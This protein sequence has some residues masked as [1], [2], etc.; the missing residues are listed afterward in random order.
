MV[1]IKFDPRGVMAESSP[2][3]GLVRNAPNS[4]PMVESPGTIEDFLGPEL[5]CVVITWCRDSGTQDLASMAETMVR[6]ALTRSPRVF[7]GHLPWANAV[8][9]DVVGFLEF[10]EGARGDIALTEGYLCVQ[11]KDGHYWWTRYTSP[12]DLN[13]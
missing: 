8:R 3:D 4:P 1:T 10:S 6:D 2:L 12:S 9:A 5:Q 11:D 7:Y 13:P